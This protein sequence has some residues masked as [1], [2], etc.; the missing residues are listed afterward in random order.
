MAR[1]KRSSVVIDKA[2]RRMAGMRSISD[3]LEFSDGL[4]LAEYH[5]RIQA[6]QMELLSYNTVLSQLD[7]M[8]GHVT[9]LERDLRSYSEKMLMSV[10]T[11]YGKDSLQYIQAG[12]KPRKR[13]S[14]SSSS[15]AIAPVGKSSA[16]ASSATVSSNG[17][18]AAVS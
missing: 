16:T 10:V 12:G 13:L 1:A 4:S 2:M 15:P 5:A 11:R 6:L 14:L 3:T 17:T 9:L 18:K 8:A 7:E